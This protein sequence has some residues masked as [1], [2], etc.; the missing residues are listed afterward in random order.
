[1]NTW[2]NYI[3]SQFGSVEKFNELP[4]AVRYGIWEEFMEEQQ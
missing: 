4:Y 1:M 3:T 2:I